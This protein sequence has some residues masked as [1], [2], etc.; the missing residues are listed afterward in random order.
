MEIEILGLIGLALLATALARMFY[1]HHLDV[2]YGP[3]VK[4]RAEGLA[5]LSVTR[6][7]KSADTALVRFRSLEGSRQCQLASTVGC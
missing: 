2:L 6:R 7:R 3:Y 5:G 4:D 1:E